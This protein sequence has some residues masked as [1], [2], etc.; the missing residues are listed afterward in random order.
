MVRWPGHVPAGIRIEPIAG[1][2]DLLPTLADLASVPVPS[3]RPLD[4]VSLKP[5]LE[6]QTKDWPDRRIFS[7]W[8]NQ[9]SVRT[10]R[11]R[12]D[13]AGKL[14]DMAADP[15]QTQDIGSENPDVLRDL[16]AA[17]KQWREE[18]PR[19]PV[20]NRPF[21]VG[22]RKL[23]LTQLPARDGV[24]HGGVE[25]SAKAP[26]CSYFTHWTSLED[27]IT[28][29][30][31]VHTA[32][33]YEIE[34]QYTCPAVDIG[35]EIEVE[36]RDRRITAKITEPHDPPARGDENDRVQREGE[37]LVKDFNRLKLGEFE[38]S[39]GRGPLTLRAIRIPGS[40][41]MEVRGV[42]MTLN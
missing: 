36:F 33:K 17:V 25:R 39:A 32:G 1:A 26:N 20:D 7:H 24:P 9:V 3:D 14:F 35:A 38:L 4:G 37:S 16:S 15:G 10:Q 11:Y 8:A 40:Q 21:T 27:S 5:L 23:P 31:E 34:I 41:V 29:D 30:I 12:L 2:I 19:L 28:W 42:L 18:C 6:G 13:A 22:Y